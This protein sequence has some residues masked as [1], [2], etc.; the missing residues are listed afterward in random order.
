MNKKQIKQ[1]VFKLLD[2]Y[3]ADPSETYLLCLINY[4][5]DNMSSKIENNERNKQI[6]EDAVY[7][8]LSLY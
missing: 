4:C 1:E 2:N 8:Y 6:I 7:E 5:R 3:L